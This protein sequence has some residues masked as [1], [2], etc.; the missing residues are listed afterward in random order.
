MRA[1]QAFIGRRAARLFIPSAARSQPDA[2]SP[3]S[4]KALSKVALGYYC[5]FADGTFV[6][7]RIFAGLLAH[8]STHIWYDCFISG[9]RYPLHKLYQM[10]SR[11]GCWPDKWVVCTGLQLWSNTTVMGCISSQGRVSL[12]V[13]MVRKE[14]ICGTGALK[15]GSAWL[16]S[17]RWTLS[18]LADGL[19]HFKL[20]DA[21]QE[22]GMQLEDWTQ[23]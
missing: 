17:Y 11:M 9:M 10:W 16:V 22:I 2:Y 20:A 13:S 1:Y 8:P 4:D 19:S 5:F 3:P 14:P 7:G 18:T 23:P 15:S 6:V 12:T 21:E